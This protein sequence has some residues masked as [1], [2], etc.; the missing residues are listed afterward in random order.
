[1]K[2]RLRTLIKLN[3]SWN[4]FMTSVLAN[5]TMEFVCAKFNFPI[6][7]RQKTY[8]QCRLLSS[9]SLEPKDASEHLAPRVEEA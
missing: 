5:L 3:Q 9:L 2:F 1:M 6:L 7:S 4:H 8:E